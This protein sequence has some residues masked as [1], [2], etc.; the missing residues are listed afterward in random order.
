MNWTVWA[1]VIVVIGAVYGLI[2]RWET[3]L[4]LLA[5]GL[6]MAVISGGPI[7]SNS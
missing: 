4:V 3:R 5:S 6:L 2:R 7:K 1:A